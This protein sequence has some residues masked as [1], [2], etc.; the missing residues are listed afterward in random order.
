MPVPDTLFRLVL[1]LRLAATVA[2]ARGLPTP[3]G[4][5]MP[6]PVWEV[7]VP[8]GFGLPA[9]VLFRPEGVVFGLAAASRLVPGLGLPAA[10][11]NVG[12]P[13]AERKVGL[14]DAFIDSRRVDARVVA[15]VCFDVMATR[16]PPRILGMSAGSFGFIT[17]P[18]IGFGLALGLPLGLPAV[19][20]GGAGRGFGM[21]RGLPAGLGL[22]L[23]LPAAGLPAAPVLGLRLAV[24]AVVAPFA[25][26]A[27][28][29]EP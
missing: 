6:M 11:R 18:G 10:E 13:T 21:A 7:A 12:L 16:E 4:F 5:G 29:S 2:P 23:G 9:A 25:A 19:F 27:G 28:L 17:A 14:P 26:P 20:D 1:D 3:E 8:G 15:V 24:V 22:P